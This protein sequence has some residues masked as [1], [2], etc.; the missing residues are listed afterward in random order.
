[1]DLKESLKSLAAL[2]EGTALDTGLPPRYPGVAVEIA[3]DRVTGVRVAE[4]GKGGPL[5]IAAAETR[6]L[7]EGA[8]E[9]SLT[10]PN[11]LAVQPVAAALEA[12]L[13]KLGGGEQR[14]SLL[15][16]DQ[17]AR[18][19][20]LPFNTLPRTRRE[21][22]ELVRFRLAKSLP[23][24]PDEA[25][26]DLM[27]LGGASTPAPA[28]V[29]VL[30]TCA[31]RAVVEQYEGLCAA[32]GFW[33]GL[34]GLSTF[35]LYNLFRPRLAPPPAYDRDTLLLNATPHDLTMLILR[36]EEIIFYRC[37][38]L[39]PGGGDDEAL[40]TLRREVY[41]SLAFYQEK[42]LGRGIGRVFLRAVG[43]AADA[44]LDA[45]ASETGAAPERLD[46]LQVL[47]AVPQASLDTRLAALAAP[48]A[49]AA[50]GRRA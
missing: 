22:A 33:P 9:P 20:I 50:A 49:G 47:P 10:R 2:F 38:P 14:L 48:A 23:F 32:A 25:V 39:P 6:D 30:A 34:V 8:I 31:L 7:P 26:L 13:A 16:P 41:T 12:V 35:E 11:V 15:I 43:S 17:V 44:V 24:K 21:L 3:P 45:V 42:L 29:S 5:R 1:V 19:A 27:V 36:G 28:G 40:A 18:V 46:L 4:E 37:K